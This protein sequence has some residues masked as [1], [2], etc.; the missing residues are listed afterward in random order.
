[1]KV[2]SSELIMLS[3]RTAPRARKTVVAVSCAELMMMTPAVL[4]LRQDVG[5]DLEAAGDDDGLHA[6]L[7]DEPVDILAV[8]DEED[9]LAGIVR[10][11][12]GA[13]RTRCAWRRP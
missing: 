3:T 12:A 8:A 7:D 11:E 5:G 2:K 10:A 4:G 6:G 1:M 13:R 9:D